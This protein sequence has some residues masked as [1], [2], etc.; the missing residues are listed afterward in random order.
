MAFDGFVVAALATSLRKALIGGRIT[1]ISQPEPDALLLTIKNGGTYRLLLSANPSLPLAYL[2]DKNKPALPTAPNFCML[3]RKHLGSARI[4]QIVQPG[5]ER[6]L[7]IELE[8]LDE[9]GDRKTKWLVLELMGKHSN[10]ILCDDSFRILDSIRHVSSLVSSVREVLPGRPY[11]VPKTV[12]KYDP[13]STDGSAAVS[14]LSEKAQPL[15]KAVYTTFTGFSPIMAQELCHRAGIDAD[16]PACE[17]T[18][19]ALDRFSIAW[20]QLLLQ[21]KATEFTPCIV[22]KDDEPVEFAAFILR[23]YG[24]FQEYRLLFPS[25]VSQTLEQ[26][27]EERDTLNRMRQKSAD[28]RKIVQTAYE[29]TVK[30][31]DL[32]QKQL[33]DTQKKDQCKLYG[34]LLMTYGYSAEPGSKSLSCTNYYTGEEVTIPLD[35]TLSATENAKRYYERYT[36]L[37]RTAEQLTLHL[38]HSTE[39]L[40]H[41]ASIRESLAYASCEADLAAIRRELTDF[42]YLKYHKP[43]SG[44]AQKE[45]KTVKS[46]PLH[47]RTSDGYDIYVGKNNY[48]NDELT[49]R[50][51]NGGDWWFHAKGVPGSHVILK[52]G[53]DEPPV[54][55][56]EAAASLAA[57]YS[58]NR[59]ADKVEVD[60]IERKHVKKPAGA[61]PG[62]VL[63]HTN[64]SM[65]AR[66]SC[67]GLTE[68]V[69]N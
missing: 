67:E 44:A 6:V 61:K 26:Y 65:M 21:T 12:E 46:A 27:Y 54:P 68:V 37:K 55:V 18:K 66:P 47:F 30:K 19:E 31:L 45:R 53:S 51:A 59:Q 4:L 40:G 69:E 3:L 34:E 62:F 8:H 60:Y 48:Q 15:Y 24:D 39:E 36:K 29:R 56:F 28:L 11:F 43:S 22:K 50:F 25:S 23:V 14:I 52:A 57:F 2:T 17:L 10:L 20:D 42:G 38:A 35:E 63:Y 58:A 41:L 33:R 49:F 64:Y 32:Q 9:L 7:Q 5:L 13:L 1:K 16:M